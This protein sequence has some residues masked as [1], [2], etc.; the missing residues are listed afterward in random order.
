M[1]ERKR[2][3]RNPAFREKE[4]PISFLE[5]KMSSKLASNRRQVVFLSVIL[6]ILLVI[7]LLISLRIRKIEVSGNHRYT[8]EQLV[9]E[10]FDTPIS[11]SLLWCYVNNRFGTH[12]TI[13]FVEDY[14]IHFTDPLAVKVIVY[15]KSVVGYVTYMGSNLYFDKDGIIVESTTERL[16]GIPRVDGMSFSHIVLGQKLPVAE[17]E[18]FPQVLELTQVLAVNGIDADSIR[19][20][21]S[22]ESTVSVGNLRVR[23]GSFVNMDAKLIELRDILASH[24]D[25]SGT[26]HLEDYDPNNAKPQFRLEPD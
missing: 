23:M 17:E 12:K 10:I 24:P 7:L 19:F 4:E 15:E 13:P 20:S 9:E 25:L 11:R 14:E 26:L 8:E 18:I 22:G 2:E 6:A 21:K 3:E 5:R 16:S 1:A